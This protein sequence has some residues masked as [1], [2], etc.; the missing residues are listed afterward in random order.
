MKN[1]NEG[2]TDEQ[3]FEQF[4]ELC[5]RIFERMEREDSFPWDE[6]GEE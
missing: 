5:K 6:D 4:V 1:K 3:K 2:L